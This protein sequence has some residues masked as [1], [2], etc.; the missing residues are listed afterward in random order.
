MIK[1]D[2]TKAFDSMSQAFLLE[3]LT[4]LGFGHIWRRLLCN[5]LA[6][7]STRVLL[8][9]RPGAP[10]RHHRGLRQGDP[11]S[12]ML[13]IIEMDVLSRL[14]AKVDEL[15]LLQPLSRRIPHHRL[16]IY[17]DDVVLFS[18]P[19]E[20]DIGLIKA[21]LHKF[22]AMSGLQ[23]NLH[24]SLILPLHCDDAMIELARQLLDCQVASFS[25]KYLGLPLSI[26]RLTKDDL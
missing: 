22:G 14:F 26:K 10:I 19:Q 8:N 17:A 11:F 21:L 7:S 3:V 6:T 24:K 15:S 9:G 2:I 23:T 1:L 5:L 13:F 4:H 12:P 18:S 20:Q 25:C 16:S